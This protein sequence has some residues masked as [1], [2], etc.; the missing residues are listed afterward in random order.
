MLSL[1][2]IIYNRYYTARTS[3]RPLWPTAPRAVAAVCGPRSATVGGDDGDGGV[4]HNI[5]RTHNMT[6]VYRA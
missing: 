6:C 1:L 5:V 4:A 2:C 3:Y